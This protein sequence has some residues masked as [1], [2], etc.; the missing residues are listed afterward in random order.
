MNRSTPFFGRGRYIPDSRR[1]GRQVKSVGTDP[2]TGTGHRLKERAYLICRYPVKVATGGLSAAGFI[3]ESLTEV[4][5]CMP[6]RGPNTPAE[7]RDRIS[8]SA[9]R[10]KLNPLEHPAGSSEGVALRP[11]AWRSTR[12]PRWRLIRQKGWFEW[13]RLYPEGRF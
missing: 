11:P 6:A 5:S 3:A 1:E 13:F 4:T 2:R 10:R 9:N 7:F 8:S 12:R